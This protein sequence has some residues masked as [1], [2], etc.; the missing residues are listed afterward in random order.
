MKHHSINNRIIRIRPTTTYVGKIPLRSLDI[1]QISAQHPTRHSLPH[2]TTSAVRQQTAKG[3]RAA[4]DHAITLETK[5]LLLIG[6]CLSSLCSAS[7]KH[8]AAVLGG[9]SL[10]EAVLDLSLTLLGLICSDHLRYPLSEKQA[11][12]PRYKN[13]SSGL[14]QMIQRGSSNQ[15]HTHVL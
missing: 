8:L 15:K 2:I 5:A 7:C 1:R 6:E 4:A 3:A 13:R 11:L 10:A 12:M 14:W 9:H